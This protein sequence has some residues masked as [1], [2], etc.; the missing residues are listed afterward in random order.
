[1]EKYYKNNIWSFEEL[2]ENKLYAAYEEP[3]IEELEDL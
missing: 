1:M 3:M 2:V